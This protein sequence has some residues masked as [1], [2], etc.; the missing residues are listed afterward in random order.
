L[1]THLAATTRCI[2][3]PDAQNHARSR[4]AKIIAA[5]FANHQANV[6]KPV[7]KERSRVRPAFSF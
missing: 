4:R 1:P 3:A 2:I 6:T 7:N 5:K